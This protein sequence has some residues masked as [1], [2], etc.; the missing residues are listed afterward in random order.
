[1]ITPLSSPCRESSAFH[2]KMSGF[3]GPGSASEPKYLQIGQRISLY[4][5]HARGFLTAP[6]RHDR[7]CAVDDSLASSEPSIHSSQSITE[8]LEDLDE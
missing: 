5:P 7:L 1:M 8:R 3:T 2:R 6:M 4:V